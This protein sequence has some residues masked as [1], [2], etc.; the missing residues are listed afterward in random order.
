MAEQKLRVTCACGTTMSFRPEQAGGRFRCPKCKQPLELVVPAAQAETRPPAPRTPQRSAPARPPMRAAR[1]AAPPPPAEEPAAPP[2]APAK[3]A[4]RSG[5]AGRSRGAAA[6]APVATPMNPKKKKLTL[7][8]GGAGGALLLVA[9][10][11]IVALKK[12]GKPEN[13]GKPSE[14]K[15]LWKLIEEDVRSAETKDDAGA[16]NA[17][18]GTA[19]A[20]IAGMRGGHD[21]GWPDFFTGRV[22]NRQ[23]KWDEALAALE[24]AVEKLDTGARVYPKMERGLILARQGNEKRL[25]T[26]R[27]RL[28][29]SS[30]FPD[31]EVDAI[32]SKA[33]PDLKL[34]EGGPNSTDFFPAGLIALAEAEANRIEGRTSGALNRLE[35]AAGVKGVAGYAQSVSGGIYYELEKW[36]LA[37]KAMDA[38][39]DAD[40]GSAW[41]RLSR[42]WG[43][44]MRAKAMPDNTDAPGWL[45]KAMADAD[46]ARKDGHPA[47]A[48]AAAAVRIERAQS[49]VDK[50][51]DPKTLLD[52]AD[53]ILAEILGKSPD[54][55]AAQELSAGVLLK[56]AEHDEKAGR[57]PRAALDRALTVLE[58]AAGGGADFPAVLSLAR[59]QVR[60]ARAEGAREGDSRPMYDRA[61][62]NFEAVRGKDPSRSGSLEP[63]LGRATAMVEKGMEDTKR[64][65]D[66]TA[67]FQ[68]AIQEMTTLGRQFPTEPGILEARGLAQRAVGIAEFAAGKDGTPTLDKAAEDLETLFKSRKSIR[69]GLTL[70]ETHMAHAE[71]LTKAGKEAKAYYGQAAAA[72]D[73][74]LTMSPGNLPLRMKRGQ[75][76]SRAGEA[77]VNG[78]HDSRPNFV[79]AIEDF[80]AVLA[81][82]ADN[83]EAMWERG[84]ALFL[85]AKSEAIGR[86]DPRVTLN[87]AITQLEKV[88]AA[89]PKHAKAL[90]ARADAILWM[91]RLEFSRG[92]D[93]LETF[94][95]SVAAWEAALG[96]SPE[97]GEAVTGVGTASV[98][99]GVATRKKGEDPAALFAKAEE[100]LKKGIEKKW[101]RAHL[102]MG[103][104]LA[105]TGKT[106]ESDAEFRAAEAEL[107][108]WDRWRV[109]AT[110]DQIPSMK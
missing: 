40:H 80:S 59:T 63:V 23:G 14:G 105:L 98:W 8:A 62:R 30:G 12:P 28:G 73:E 56:R 9:I 17:A 20:K 68:A 43:L 78:Q 95:R 22:L 1:P 21:Y 85:S 58:K 76:L 106:D 96:V 109:K 5:L 107:P 52:E 101:A 51:E 66:A 44:C 86:Q 45:D 24:K 19:L 93:A 38:G 60:R 82:Q 18:L 16:R 88:V 29:G 31:P 54:G 39:F 11:L 26:R 69:I 65:V 57:D 102:G 46:A 71:A 49:M 92:A 81:V 36:E 67:V 94:K 77:D 99:L 13:A 2:P 97:S 6:S 100:N 103:L 89:D 74:I 91:G 27:F 70:A 48:L 3:P 35:T 41:A 72:L 4:G 33:L 110:K 37:M 15:E 42:A 32:E 10:V 61:I 79:R 53:G 75:A 84:N 47:G 104:V 7:I 55:A 90:A 25:A 83:L 34:A 87:M 108:E 64:G 50:G